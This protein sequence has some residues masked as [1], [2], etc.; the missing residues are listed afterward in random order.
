MIAGAVETEGAA[1]DAVTLAELCVGDEEP[2]TV[3][4]RIRA[5]GV[6]ILNTPAAAA[7]ICAHAYKDYRERR[8]RQSG[9]E[10]SAVPLPDFFIGAHAQLMGW[11]LA[12]AD[13]SRL[14]TYF[15]SVALRLPPPRSGKYKA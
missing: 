10:A 12:T 13:E 5:W 6:G 4:Q 15:P 7:E 1:I 11:S 8:V 3:A 14:K 2:G 9:K